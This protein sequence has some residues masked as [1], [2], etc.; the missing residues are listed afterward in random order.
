MP[1]TQT[2]CKGKKTKKKIQQKEWNAAIPENR[3]ANLKHTKYKTCCKNK[4]HAK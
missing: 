4:T 2:A 1:N 3:S